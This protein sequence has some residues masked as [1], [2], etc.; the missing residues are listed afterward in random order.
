MIIHV[1]L[2]YKA[3]FK[4]RTSFR[5]GEILRSWFNYRSWTA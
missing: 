4:N 5:I 3:F 1:C 2:I